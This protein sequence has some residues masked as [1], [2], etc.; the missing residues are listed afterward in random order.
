MSESMT[1]VVSEG[2]LRPQDLIPKFLDELRFQDG[3]AYAQVIV[4][5]RI[6]PAHAFE[7]D[8]AEWW[9]SEEASEMVNGLQDALNDVAPN[10]CYFGTL[11]GDGACFGFF[12]IEDRPSLDQVSV[13]VEDQGGNLI[14]TFT[15]RKTYVEND[16]DE[17][18][19]SIRGLLGK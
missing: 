19:D 12:S 13:D 8:D 17:F 6:P 1:K 3:T 4:D 14:D 15:I 5:G 2:T 9:R 7:D 10:G 18:G 11:E 16:L